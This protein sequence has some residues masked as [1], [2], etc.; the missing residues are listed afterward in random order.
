MLCRFL[1]K[2]FCQLVFRSHA[3]IRLCV[4]SKVAQN[5][6]KNA[7]LWM[8]HPN[9]EG[10]C[11]TLFIADAIEHRVWTLSLLLQEFF[12]KVCKEE[13][14]LQTLSDATD[15]GRVM[16]SFLPRDAQKRMALVNKAWQRV[17]HSGEVYWSSSL[18]VVQRHTTTPKGSL[19]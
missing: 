19:F 11:S 9:K 3:V 18:C 16:T 6:T 10:S 5:K 2:I 12:L 1:E 8:D 15:V 7:T 13:N 14:K 17:R 4:S